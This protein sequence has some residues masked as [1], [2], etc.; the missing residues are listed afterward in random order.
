MQDI[1]EKI[2]KLFCLA[3]DRYHEQDLRPAI[4]SLKSLLQ[5]DFNHLDAHFL[6]AQIYQ[7]DQSYELSNQHLHHC[8]KNG[9]QKVDLLKILAFNNMQ[10]GLLKEA[11]YELQKHLKSH[12]DDADGYALLG[13]IYIKQQQY[14]YAKKVYQ[15]AIELD[16]KTAL[17]YFKLAQICH[18]LKESSQ[19]LLE[20]QKALAIDPS[21]HQ[22]HFLVATLYAHMDK[23]EQAVTSYK[24]AIALNNIIPIY[25]NNLAVSLQKLDRHDEALLEQ[26]TALALDPDN[27]HFQKNLKKL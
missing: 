22:A 19:A 27:K 14:H 5:L 12:K 18:A 4:E 9:Y 20:A 13:D 3:R 8:I 25:Y 26:K 1:N 17:Y 23:D 10:L 7:K 11:I 21:F 2:E 16:P 6:L 24:K 15:Q